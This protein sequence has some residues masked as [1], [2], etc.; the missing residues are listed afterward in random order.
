MLR[1]KGML[2]NMVFDLQ[3]NI[4]MTILNNAELCKTFNVN[5]IFLKAMAL[6]EHADPLFVPELNSNYVF[7]EKILN[8]VLL[9][10]AD[11]SHDC[12]FLSGA[13]GCGKT[14]LILQIASR[15]N[16]PVQSITVSN[17]TEIQDLIGHP[18]LKNGTLAF[19]YGALTNA[20]LKGEILLINEI[21]MIGAGE[22]S[23]LNDVLEGK[24][25]VIVQN[26][27]EVIK[28][29]KNFRVIATGNT[30][31]N[32][33][34]TGFYNGTRILNK[35]FL[36]RWRFIECTY[37]SKDNEINIIKKANPNLTDDEVDKLCTLSYEIRRVSGGADAVGIST[38]FST[39]TLLRIAHLFASIDISIYEAVEMGFSSR[40]VTL[41]HDYID[42]LTKDI[43]GNSY[44]RKSKVADPVVITDTVKIEPAVTEI[45][46]VKKTRKTTKKASKAVK[47]ENDTNSEHEP[48][49]GFL[50][51]VNDPLT[52]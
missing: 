3:G 39:R 37:T 52:A 47:P 40:L 36:D 6:P 11:P 1:T 30:K 43:F 7:D 27:G 45:V 50:E 31:G 22:L 24:P 42:R 10:L 4:D 18:V 12:L 16:Y 20:M 49:Q 15:L 17:K 2:L 26:K 19:E 9:F 33:D 28:P 38:P 35:A 51:F 14:S 41:E 21:D 44:V 23:A 5:K 46:K 13:S 25:L 29:H 8:Q 48:H 34:E 32:D